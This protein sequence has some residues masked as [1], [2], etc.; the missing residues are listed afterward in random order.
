MIFR[1]LFIVVQLVFIHSASTPYQKCDITD[2][3]CISKSVQTYLPFLA[4]GLPEYGTAPLDPMLVDEIKIELAGLILNMRDLDI[5]GLKRS[6]IEKLDVDMKKQQIHLVYGSDIVMKGRYKAAG[7]LLILPI[8]GD[9]NCNIKLKNLKTDLTMPF[10][11]VKNKDGVEVIE[12]SSYKF[13]FEVRDYAHFD[14]TNLFNGNKLLG[15]TML[16]FI[17]TNWKTLM[18]EFG[19]PVLDSAIKNVYSAIKTYLKNQPLQDIVNL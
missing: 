6:K 5:V 8:S 4:E 18:T 9:G 19:K 12:L 15:E 13:K 17:N 1:T 14:L 16:T 10:T 2:A 7:R 11:I 3:P